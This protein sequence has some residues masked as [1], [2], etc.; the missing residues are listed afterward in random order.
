MGSSGSFSRPWVLL[1][2]I[3]ALAVPEGWDVLQVANFY[4]K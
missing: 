2:V 1:S 4:L 3:C